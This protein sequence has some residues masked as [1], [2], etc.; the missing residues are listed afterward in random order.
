MGAD[1]EPWRIG[2]SWVFVRGLLIAGAG[3]E[4]PL[5]KEACF[6]DHRIL[7]VEILILWISSSRVKMRIVPLIFSKSLER[8]TY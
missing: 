7:L 3:R 6:R 5:F 1:L 4:M 8:Y 2:T